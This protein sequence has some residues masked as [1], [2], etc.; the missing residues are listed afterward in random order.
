[1]N[2]QPSA[3]PDDDVGFSPIDNELPLRWFRRLHLVPARGLGTV[4]RALFFALVTW[5]PIVIWAAMM[6]RG[7]E[8]DASESLLRHYGVHARC[9]IAIPLFILAEAGLH[10][11]VMRMVS[12]FVSSGTVPPEQQPAFDAALHDVRGLRD[13]SLPWVL[14]FGATIAWLLVDHPAMHD[15]AY[16]WAFA[17]DSALGFGG[18]W[19]A[20][21]ARPI[22]FA[23]LLSWL[24][25]M[26]LVVYW[27]WRVGRLE[28]SLV[29]SHP[30]HTGGVG[31]VEKLPGAF[32][33]VTFAVTAVVTSRWAHELASHG[34]TLQAF[35]MPAAAFVLLWALFA[36][37]PLLMLT[38]MLLAARAKA[39]PAYGALVGDQGRLVHRRW[40]LR[41]PVA[42]API[43]D[44][45]EIGPVADAA[46]LY[47]AVR[48]MRFVPIG[49]MALIAVLVPMAIPML[50][51]AGLQIP[52]G[53]LLLKL[54][55]TV[56]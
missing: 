28:L 50:V 31:F 30:D 17:N 41:E 29:P 53:E 10:G 55:K 54:L 56:L 39:V 27:F 42:G 45:P 23:L 21:V 18:W 2:A 14:V 15:D 6:R 44:A 51:V 35:A 48:K 12:L 9:L 16:A 24:W 36:L 4:R 3:P 52:L 38:P 1:M 26:L 33:L 32:A 7:A 43:L 20:Y 5:L 47:D 37:L 8:P 46:A 49:K 11:T 22:F 13:S 25:R 19:F 40:I 34:A